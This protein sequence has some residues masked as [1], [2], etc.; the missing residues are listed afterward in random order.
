MI[1]LTGGTG[2][3]GAQL[4]EL[5]AQAHPKVLATKRKHSK[6][7]EV[8]R[9]YTNIEWLECNVK[10]YLEVEEALQGVNTVFHCAAYVSFNLKHQHKIFETNVLGTEHIVNACLKLGVQRLYHI[11]SVASLGRN[12]LGSISEK[13]MFDNDKKQSAYAKSKYLSEMEVWRGYKEG[14]KGCIVNPSVI[15]GPTH[16]WHSGTGNLIRSSAKGR[17]HFSTT[18][19]IGIVDVR[20]VAKAVFELSKTDISEE[21]FILNGDNMTYQALIA[22]INATFNPKNKNIVIGKN[23]LKGIAI[24]TKIM[25]FF[26]GQNPLP[27][28][29]VDTLSSNLRYSSEKLKT[30]INFEFT[31]F[32][33]TLAD[34]KKSYT[35]YNGTS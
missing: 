14:L 11:S 3:V 18:G 23:R 21:Q 34:T 32:M 17:L 13:N 19:S 7:P 26:T 6:I 2:F 16:D 35:H 15:I 9:T 28:T 1:L 4:L 27:F 22:S 8:L 5:L 30:A 29:L 12:P 10:N 33:Q 31:P 25:S 24:L 20:D